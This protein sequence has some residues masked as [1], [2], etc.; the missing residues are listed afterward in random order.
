MRLT[1]ELILLMLNEQTGYLEMEPGWKFSC[2]IAGSV[3][4]DLALENRIDTDIEKAILIDS[5]P[6]GDELLDPT[7]EEFAKAGKSH[8]A[9]YWVEKNTKRADEILTRTLN[10][11]VE[12]NILNYETGGFWSLTNEVKRLKSYPTADQKLREEAKTRIL[13]VIMDEKIPDP[14]D[15]ILINLLHNC[16][17]FK[18][19]MSVEDFSEKLEYIELICKLDLVGQAISTAVKQSVIAPKFRSNLEANRIPKLSFLDILRERDFYKGNIPKAMCE[20]YNKYGPVV[21]IPFKMQKKRLIALIGPEANT[22]AHKNGRFYLRSKD[23]IEHFERSMGAHRTL[24]GLD[25]PD[26]Y[27]MRKSLSVGYSRA[28]LANRLPELIHNCGK[29]IERW[30]QGDVFPATKMFQNHV[31]SQ[32]S[33]FVI[34]V[35]CSSYIDDVLIYMHRALMVHVQG[36][37]KIALRT[38]RMKK[39]R[40]TIERMI[41]DIHASHTPGQRK[42]KLPDLADYLLDLHRNDP[43][44][45]PETDI[46]FPFAAA[47]V[48][49]IY[50][51]SALGFSIFSMYR[52]PELYEKVYQEAESIF[53]NGRQPTDADFTFETASVANRLWMEC[54][55][56]YPVIPWQL[57]TTMNSCNVEGFRIPPDVMILQCYSATHYLENLYKDPLK[58]DI[59]RFL[60]GREEHMAQGAYAPYGLGTHTCLGHRWVD[61]QMTVNILMIAYH[62]KLEIVPSNYK[63]AI[64]PFP[65]AAPNAKLKFKVAEVRNSIS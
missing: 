61:L 6:T 49:S 22:W 29:S 26:H 25:G 2:V 60:P 46:S 56:A 65:T 27:K 62:S 11:L 47:I 42:D 32:I 24:P 20:I 30:N 4:A 63:L 51:G 10:R 57:R 12:K 34:G 53:G 40:K 44:F 21:E 3:I 8:D 41:G 64:N 43:A 17:G 1:E 35:D 16:G 14:R 55:R 19:I 7:L 5:T 9:Q 54:Q 50:L 18:L 39:A 31:S 45:L 23:Y 59:D 38:P 58:F 48:A 37:P 13:N 36:L 28:T 33:Q 52:D 15:A